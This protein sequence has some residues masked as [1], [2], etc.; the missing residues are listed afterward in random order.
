MTGLALDAPDAVRAISALVHLGL[1]GY[2][3]RR[4]GK[5]DRSAVTGASVLVAL[6][7]TALWSLAGMAR[8]YWDGPVPALMADLA[9]VGRYGAWFVFLLALG[10][11]D[12]DAT[13][14]AASR[15]L[16]LAAVLAL[17]LAVAAQISLQSPLP[18]A[19]SHRFAAMTGL[20]LSV[21]G[22]LMV[23]QLFRNAGSDVLWNIKPVCLGLGCV[24]GFDVYLSS[25]A[26]LFAGLGVD[27]LIARPAVHALAVPFLFVASR[28]S[29]GWVHRLEVSRTAAFYSATLILVGVYLLF[30]A[31]V[32]YYLRYVGGNW[33]RPAQ[34]SLVAGALA[35]LGWLVL[36]GTV[37]SKL[38][39]FISKHFF[40]YRY[41]YRQEW[42]KFTALLSARSTPSET[43]EQIVRGLAAM[44]ECPS[45]SLWALRPDG[46]QF[47]QATRWNS[48]QVTAAE[49]VAS[50]F[51]SFM[52]Q[53]CWV[54]DLGEFRSA[55]Q[56]YG[57][58]AMPDWLLGL[59]DAWLIVPLLAGDSLYGFVVLGA[60]RARIAL[61][62]EVLDLLK[63]AGRQAAAHLV[64]MQTTEALLEARKFD[65]FN[66]MSAFVVH[67]LKNIV[68]QLSLMLKNAER[69]HDNPE[70]QQDMLTTVENALRRMKRLMMQL[71][72][73][74][75]PATGARGLALAPLVARLSR[76]AQDQGRQ[77][78]VLC[79]DPGLATRG[80]EDRLERVL[81]HLVQNALDATPP[82]GRVW[83]EVSRAR[84]QVRMVVGDTGA[85]MSAEFIRTR[86]FKPF[87]ST[88][89]AGMGIGSYESV[90]YVHELGGQVQVDSEP[91]QGTMITV[92]LPLLDMERPSNLMMLRETP[93]YE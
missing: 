1:L 39:V 78:D 79:D 77:L 55:P 31:A 70:F 74:S 71:R 46:L 5:A 67:D 32:G 3:L 43:G 87:S 4:M 34:V 86:L 54:L 6:A 17:G 57:S 59:P 89:P 75:Q 30:V 76:L 14:P 21:L 56:R 33:A 60:P 83:L 25:E 52:Q 58:L 88:K 10:P 61:N 49:P 90:Q 29:A 84:G 38:R 69:H 41:D 24:F 92:L 91:G 44:V 73:G 64:Q 72:E 9:S 66:R 15:A 13:R 47:E 19:A 20:A 37:R 65:A 85:G 11:Q 7:L 68:T 81:G 45:G 40:R 27:T 8:L 48:A 28:R 51:C 18:S 36:S 42:L 2:L 35:L 82:E 62:W 63:T 53:R 80:H 93:R 26:L 16:R 12:T 50:P 22:L 23:E